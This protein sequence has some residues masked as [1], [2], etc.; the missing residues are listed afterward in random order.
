MSKPKRSELALGTALPEPFPEPGAT[1]GPDP[2][3][4]D[5][6]KGRLP[7]EFWTDPLY[8]PYY[9]R[10][11]K[12]AS[13]ER[14]VDPTAQLH[15]VLT[16]IASMVPPTIKSA[17]FR[18]GK[19]G[20]LNYLAALA[21]PPGRG[22][23]KS[24]ELVDELVPNIIGS[25]DFRDGAKP[26]SG[27]G[28]A[29]LFER[30]NDT[31][32]AEKNAKLRVPNV[33]AWLD[34]GMEFLAI[35]TRKNDTT[36]PTLCTA[37]AG[38]NISG[39]RANKI[40]SRRVEAGTY[41]L[42]FALGI[43]P[44]LAGPLF[45]TDEA[46]LL[47]RFMWSR[48]ALSENLDFDPDG[49]EQPPLDIE[50]LGWKRPD[51]SAYKDRRRT[52]RTYEMKLP[53]TARGDLW[54]WLNDNENRY[55]P[56]R[57]DVHAPWLVHKTACLLAILREELDVSEL[58]WETAKTLV[59]TSADARTWVE[60]R[61]SARSQFEVSK[62]INYQAQLKETELAVEDRHIEHRERKATDRI[63]LAIYRKIETDG[64]ATE[65]AVKR[66]LASRDRS[67][68]GPAIDQAIRQ[69]WIVPGDVTGTYVPGPNQPRSTA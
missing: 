55:W 17:N 34:E 4:G 24:G 48:P 32:G 60:D 15:M 63:A 5:H 50:P 57:H 7:D 68:F 56:N 43:Q 52:D 58:D 22:K 25:K 28:L 49:W 1:T 3:S 61:L 59:H 18:G 42:G 66:V 19:R 54:V 21:A 16:R 47:Q 69:G 29:A 53:A 38:G 65:G 67:N 23:S 39:D 36:T 13:D 20:S 44:D 37:W 27:Q 14:L 64:S 40:D 10:Q 12:R 45:D 30:D 26:Q 2:T 8:D 35:A 11:I 6:D 62:K 31:E 33:Y 46:G 41:S 51:L 9:L